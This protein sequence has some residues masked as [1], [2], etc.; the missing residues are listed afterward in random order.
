MRSALGYKGRLLRPFSIAAAVLACTLGATACTG[1]TG[2]GAATSG[3]LTIANFTIPQS[4]SPADSA[5]NAPGFPVTL[6][7]DSLI[8]WAPDNTYKPMLAVEWGYVG[9][10]NTK[11]SFTLRSGVQFADGEPLTAQAA[12]D[13]INYFKKGKNPAAGAFKTVTAEAT[14]E[15]TVTLTLSV[16]NPDVERMLSQF[17]LGGALISPKGLQNPS[18]LE[19]TSYGAGPYVLEAS[20]SVAGD[21]YT[22]TANP[23]YWDKSRVHWSKIVVKVYTD[24]NAALS[25]LKL[26][27][28]QAY[29]GGSKA[30]EASA[31]AAG[32]QVLTA[33]AFWQGLQLLDT[34]GKVVKALGDVRVRQAISYAIDRKAIVDAIWG[35]DATIRVQPANQSNDGF[36][37]S[38]ESRYPYDPDKAKQLLAEAGYPDGFSLPVVYNTGTTFGRL[39]QA[40]GG[41]LAK[42][43]IE[44]EYHGVAN[45]T[46]I[47]PPLYSGTMAAF[48]IPEAT[49]SVYGT[50]TQDFA[51]SANL[52]G[53]NQV[54]PKLISMYNEAATLSGSAA[55]TAWRNILTYMVDEA[56][57]VPIVAAP[58]YYYIGKDI[59]GAKINP[60]NGYLDFADLQ[61]SS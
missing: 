46:D 29:L 23:N 33:P 13:S 56:I 60:G 4:L 43:G 25:A 10:G 34:Q 50:I 57:T 42:V 39:M 40:I 26:G 44:L 45:F 16:P 61:P 18:A 49:Y 2:T 31:Q 38:L 36:D 53:N 12:A 59:S 24:E 55:T 9:T 11:F 48:D 41:D 5:N 54:D 58:Q 21:H 51:P 47:F 6:A 19:T 22:Y 20:Q 14:G 1:S 27:E 7:Y 17:D 52:N 28:V 3:T 32:I 8:Y 30:T 37:P 35:S 15:L